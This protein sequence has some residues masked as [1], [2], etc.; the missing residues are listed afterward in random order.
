MTHSSFS[1]LNDLRQK[2]YI[3]FSSTY[4]LHPSQH[5]PSK[6]Q[7]TIKKI[8]LIHYRVEKVSSH[9]MYVNADQLVYT[10]LG[11][12]SLMTEQKTQ[13]LVPKLR[14]RWENRNKSE[15]N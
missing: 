8:F 1:K 5:F 13:P 6:I 2:I 11:S 3:L 12:V 4:P 7:P 15:G 10:R 9:E 14:V